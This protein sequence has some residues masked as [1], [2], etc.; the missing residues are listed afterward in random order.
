L[1]IARNL[2]M[3]SGGM[4]GKLH[5]M[6]WRGRFS[7]AAV[8][9]LVAL[10]GGCSVG[11][12]GGAWGV[13][14]SDEPS[15]KALGF[16]PES[17][18]KSPAPVIR[19]QADVTCPPVEVR[20]GASTLT[21]GPQ[22][23]NNNTMSLKYQGT[24]VR[25]ARDCS[26]VGSDMVIKVGIQGRIVIGPAG[27]PG[28]V[29]VPVRIAVVQEAPGGFKPVMTKL[30]RIPVTV[31][32]GQGNVVFTHVEPG[33]T[34]PVPTPSSVLDDYIVYVGFDALA[35]E[36]QEGAKPKTKSKAKPA[37]P[38]ADGGKPDGSKPDGSKPD[39]S[40]PDGSKPASSK[41][42]SSR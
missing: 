25:A 3:N 35:A 19:A 21:V 5:P 36:P 11:G 42:E 13:A 4:L 20:E 6:N 1:E 38:K 23:E 34:F 14:G 31:P 2:A 10:A 27:G 37:P 30:I 24:F 33:V 22:G 8:P 15:S 26:V 17:A 40:K 29:Q 9:L 28:D 32:P 12:A 18:P 39:G 41:A 16:S 7:F